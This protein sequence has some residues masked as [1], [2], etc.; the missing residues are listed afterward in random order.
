VG[1]P[2][3]PFFGLPLALQA[4]CCGNVLWAWNRKH[5]ELMAAVVGSRLRERD[6]ISSFK[7]NDTLLAKLPRWVKAAKNREPVLSC[8]EKLR[9]MATG[10]TPTTRSRK[11]A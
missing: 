7:S 5:L 9:A 1:K 6:R 11:K 10:L 4:P 3:D 8:I 2:V